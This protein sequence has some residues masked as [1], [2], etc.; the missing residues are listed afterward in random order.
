MTD[1][2]K[3]PGLIED[4]R[5]QEL[6]DKD[7][8]SK[9]T[10]SM[11][12]SLKWNR[13]INGATNYSQR[14]QN[15]SGSCV[16]QSS[17][18]ALEILRKGEIISA[19]PIY[20][21]RANYPGFGMS[22][23]DA[24]NIVKNLGTTTEELDP[25][26]NMSEAQMNAPVTVQTPINGYLYAFPKFKDID[27]IATAIEFY[28][29]CKI[30]VGCNGGEWSE[31]PVYNGEAPN[32]F[33]DICATYY[34][35]DEQGNKCLR[36]DES[37]GR[38]NTGHRVLTETF[39]KLRCTGA[40]YHIPPII[41][42]TLQKPQFNFSVP[43]LYKDNNYSVKMIQDI[44]KYENLFP[45]NISSTGY[46]GEITRKSVLAFQRKYQVAGED[47]LNSLN[48]KRVGLKTIAKLNSL[49]N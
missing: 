7:Y 21:R 31:K 3:N 48:G 12:I 6:K 49:Y 43:L 38:N 32:L 42:P 25:S 16:A 10:M 5:S 29:H 37:W 26:Q 20:A 19:H 8:S 47:E 23:Q 13:D 46:Y 36:I 44:L 28:K 35:T 34:F 2:L 18:K 40:M 30:A 11:A 45:I 9:E 1:E 39:L 41:P 24:G 17:A 22:L 15:G 33:H 4:T 14:N 27:E